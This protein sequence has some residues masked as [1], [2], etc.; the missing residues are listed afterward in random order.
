MKTQVC[1]RTV[2]LFRILVSHCIH[3]TLVHKPWTDD[4]QK[5]PLAC[6]AYHDSRQGMF[7]SIILSLFLFIFLGQASIIPYEWDV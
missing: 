4:N 2:H 5:L 6:P 1:L 3:R 7:F